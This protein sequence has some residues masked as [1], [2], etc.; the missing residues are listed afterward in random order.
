MPETPSGSPV[1]PPLR[2][3]LV[4]DEPAATNWLAELLSRHQHVSVVGRATDADRAE[5]LIARLKPDVVFVDIEMP[6]R[7]GLA[8]LDRLDGRTLGVVVT[9]FEDYAVEAFDTAAVDYLLKPVTAAR[10]GRTLARLAGSRGRSGAVA[11]FADDG[12]VEEA[13]P[14]PVG[15]DDKF[16]VP[17]GRATTLVAADE[18]LWLEALDN[19]S[20][21]HRAG[22]PPL[23]VRRPL[24]EWE[25][26]LPPG[27]F[28]RLDRSLIVGLDR[29]DAIHWRW[30]GGTQV[31]FVGSEA[32]LTLGRAATR[33]LKDR[34][35]GEG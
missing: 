4:D 6:G 1:L 23:T 21:V 9:A 7:D 15:L 34:L 26:A 35:D 10:L 22:A 3:L 13:P 11:P 8:L 17:T 20:L 30:Q 31:A 33:R 27:S 14:E 32:T 12:S 5:R 2:V 18:I 24:A 19:Y 25:A 29:I 28:L 16:A